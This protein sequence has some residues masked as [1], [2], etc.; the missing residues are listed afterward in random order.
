MVYQLLLRHMV[1]CKIH[2]LESLLGLGSQAPVHE[3]PLRERHPPL[4]RFASTISVESI[5]QS[6]RQ[7]LTCLNEILP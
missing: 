6:G 3:S 7:L 4:A 1:P 2:L 5:D